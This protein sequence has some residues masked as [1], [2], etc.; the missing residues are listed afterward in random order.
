LHAIAACGDRG[1]DLFFVISGFCLAYPALAGR[2]AGSPLPALNV[3]AYLR[4]M[5]RRL[6]SSRRH[7]TLQ[8]SRSSSSLR[9]ITA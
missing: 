7:I 4:F 8:L 1:V 9:R 2:T 5:R 3:A 6:S